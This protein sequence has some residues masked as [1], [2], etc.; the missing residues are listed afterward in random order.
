MHRESI[1]THVPGLDLAGDVIGT[2]L[3]PAKARSA[4]AEPGIISDSH[5]VVDAVIHHDGHDWTEYFL[6]CD[7]HNGRDLREDCGIEVVTFVEAGAASSSAAHTTA[8][9][10]PLL[11]LVHHAVAFPS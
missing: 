11:N 3:I 1:H 6:L 8:P 2:I 7:R 5:R 10:Y 4:Q 9:F